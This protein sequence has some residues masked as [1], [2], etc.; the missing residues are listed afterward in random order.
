MRYTLLSIFCLIT[1]FASAQN[2]TVPAANNT[3]PGDSLAP[4]TTWYKK[5]DDKLVIALYTSYRAYNISF[6]QSVMADS[7]G[8]SKPNYRADAN[9]VTGVELNYDKFSVS[10]GIKSTP[11]D[12]KKKGKTDYTAFNFSFGGNRWI[13]ETS[14]RKYKGFYDLNTAKYDTTYRD[15]TPYFLNPQMQNR[16]VRA[17]FLYFFNHEELS[18]KSAYTCTYRQF[19]S[20]YS[21][22]MVGNIYQNVLG[23]D[24]SFVSPLLRPF[25][26]HNAYLNHIGTFGISYGGGFSGN[27]V[28][29]KSVFV[30]LTFVL[31]V[32][33]QWRTYGYL[34]GPRKTFN[35][36]SISGDARASIG[37]NTRD[38]FMTVS[39]LNDFYSTDGFGLKSTTKFLSGA[40]TIGY[41]FP[42]EDPGIVKKFRKT[43]LYG[44]M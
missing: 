19:K 37:I 18:Y 3:V 34:D 32:E 40:F 17:K 33:S 14:Y 41:R 20:A 43:K 30:N 38:F 4:D 31:G 7:L 11:P 36:I 16:S 24:T 2:D 35:Y 27:L 42:I 6:G 13:L 1:S 8:I 15:T 9:Q 5:Y 28:L 39:S 25:Y 26:G 23:T 22:V 21:G 29:W 12:V 10:F 44:W